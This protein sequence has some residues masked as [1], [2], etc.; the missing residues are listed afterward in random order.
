MPA[1]T[2]QRILVDPNAGVRE[3]N[4]E[5][6]TFKG[7]VCAAAWGETAEGYPLATRQVNVGNVDEAIKLCYGDCH[8]L[9]PCPCTWGQYRDGGT[10]NCVS[11]NRPAL[12]DWPYGARPRAA[13]VVVVAV[14]VVAVLLLCG[15][16]YGTRQSAHRLAQRMSCEGVVRP[17]RC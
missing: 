6:E 15:W 4:G 11:C 12:C 17:S 14:V 1:N 10:N 8:Q 13:P 5:I 3:F 9:A 2:A 7:Q 16:P